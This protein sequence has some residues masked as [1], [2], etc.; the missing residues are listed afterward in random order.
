[1]T[2]K[3]LANELDITPQAIY[4]KIKAVNLNLKALKD[5]ETGHLTDDG[6]KT[7]VNLFVK[8]DVNEQSTKLVKLEVENA[9]LRQQVDTLN[10]MV[11]DLRA[12]RDAWREQARIQQRLTMPK[13][14]LWARLIG[15]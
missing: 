9:A 8:Q 4:Q 13:P 3:E 14:S 5:A 10:A 6:I 1:M 11:D 7:I 15:K 2:I 12:D